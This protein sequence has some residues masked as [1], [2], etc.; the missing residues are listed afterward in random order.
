MSEKKSTA[1]PASG[2]TDKKN[3]AINQKKAEKLEKQWPNKRRVLFRPKRSSYILGQTRSNDC[4]FCA[5]LAQG[6]KKSSLVI[7]KTRYSMVILNKYP[8]NVGHLLVLPQVHGGDPVKLSTKVYLDVQETVL[9]CVD[10]LQRVYEPAG[11][12]I[13]ANL[14]KAAGA[15]IPQHLHYHVIPRWR[16]DLNFFQLVAES[17]T[18]IETVEQTYRR[19]LPYFKA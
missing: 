2:A 18:V 4:V 5:A 17:K 9:K 16:G 6:V 11:L 1:R 12:N 8:Y 19:L 10:I 13:G 14:G 7:Y 15:G 3:K